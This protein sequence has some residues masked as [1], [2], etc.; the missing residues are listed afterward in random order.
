[1]GEEKIIRAVMKTEKDV[2]SDHQDS[3]RLECNNYRKKRLAN[4]SHQTNGSDHNPYFN[5]G[6][7]ILG[8]EK[9]GQVKTFHSITDMEE[10]GAGVK[11]D[12]GSFTPNFTRLGHMVKGKSEDDK[13]GFWAMTSIC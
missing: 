5:D 2:R 6:I 8:C 9:D 1:M 12:T 4:V 11:K 13:C 7:T 3:N 10:R